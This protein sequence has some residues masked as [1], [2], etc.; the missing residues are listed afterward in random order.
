MLDRS[1]GETG[2]EKVDVLAPFYIFDPVSSCPQGKTTVKANSP[3]RSALADSLHLDGHFLRLAAPRKATDTGWEAVKDEIWPF[4]L[5]DG[6][7]LTWEASE[8]GKTSLVMVVLNA[9]EDFPPSFQD[10]TFVSLHT[11][12]DSQGLA[13]LQFAAKACR[14]L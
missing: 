9:R 14:T 11:F 13:N 5:R 1:L 3:K 8:N 12:T 2:V 6:D 10:P 7:D 4:S